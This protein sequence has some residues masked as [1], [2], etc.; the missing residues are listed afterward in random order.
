MEEQVNDMSQTLQTI[1]EEL[2]QLR[3][4][5][6][7]QYNL[8]CQLNRNSGAQ[9]REIRS[10]RKENSILRERLSKYEQPPKDSNNSSTPACKENM[11]SEMKRRTKSLRKKSDKPI[12]G[13]K[14]HE[15]STREKSGNVDEIVDHTSDYC[16]CCGDEFLL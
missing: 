13:Q 14:G 7:A 12:G 3:Q 6:D 1:V 4:N 16:S 2:Q 5:N 10:L 8:I 11:E 15:G 9:L